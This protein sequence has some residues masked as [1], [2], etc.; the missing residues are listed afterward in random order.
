M[1]VYISA[2]GAFAIAGYLIFSS[3]LLI[4]KARLSF[5]SFFLMGVLN[6]IAAFTTYLQGGN[7]KIQMIYVVGCFLLC[8]L[9][10][11]IGKFSWGFKETLVTIGILLS[12]SVWYAF[13]EAY[14]LYVALLSLAAAL[15]LELIDAWRQPSIHSVLPWFIFFL[16]NLCMFKAAKNWAPEE[17]YYSYL[18][19]T[20][21]L[22][23]TLVNLRA[24]LPQHDPTIGYIDDDEE[25][26]DD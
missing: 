7:Y 25:Y 9:V 18:G 5:A 26:Y 22:L 24:A 10:V 13:G 20:S 12:L 11:A 8:M 19:M 1:D 14:G 3:N 16:A 4:Q 17:V 15:V 23:L 21:S 2:G 6:S